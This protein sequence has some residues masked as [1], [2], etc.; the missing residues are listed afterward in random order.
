[1]TETG[2]KTVENKS[3]N[4]SGGAPQTANGQL[5]YAVETRKALLAKLASQSQ[6]S[7]AQTSKDRKEVPRSSWMWPFSRLEDAFVPFPPVVRSMRASSGGYRAS[8]P[9]CPAV[10]SSHWV[11][12]QSHLF[13]RR[14]LLGDSH[15]RCDGIPPSRGQ[16]GSLILIVNRRKKVGVPGCQRLAKSALIESN[17]VAPLSASY[18]PLICTA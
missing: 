7:V 6:S 16:I 17:T 15:P 2:F 18:F 5:F 4:L 9:A 8:S 12:S 3:L 1:M 10:T 11:D 14:W 13:A